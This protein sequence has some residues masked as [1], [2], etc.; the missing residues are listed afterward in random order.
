M[1]KEKAIIGDNNRLAAETQIREEQ[2]EV[3]YQTK[4]F[5]VELLVQK[6]LE[7]MDSDENEIF[8][9][10]YQREFVWSKPRQSKFIESVMLGLPIPYIFIASLKKSPDEDEGRAEIVD[11]S[12]RI[13]TLSDF[14]K[15]QLKLIELQKLDKLNGFKFSDLD[16]S[17]QRKFK[18]Q[19]I[20]VIELS[21]K[22]NEEVRRD[23]FER[24]NTGSDELRD[25]EKRKGIFTGLF[26]DFIKECA[27]SPEFR[28]VCP[29]SHAK[30]KREEAEEL[31]LRYFAYTD[32]YHEFKHSVREFLN[33][34]FKKQHSSFDKSNMQREFKNMVQFVK[35]YF[36]YGFCKNKASKSV[37][38]VR[39][40]AI[41]VGVTLAQ[42]ETKKLTGDKSKISQWL[43][44]PEFK[45]LVTSD[46][47]NSLPRLKARVEFVRNKLMGN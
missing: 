33:A 40:E 45:K 37:P 30:R 5:T 42:R 1:P 12:Q 28:A 13:R 39:F 9:P 46:A 31:V 25:M 10:D 18:R 21:E 6:Y 17:R 36:P 29:V 26:Y 43:E 22:A 3:D 35:R 44:S 27:N 38:R 34:Y 8:I 16:L 32:S 23:L 14:L 24:I 41:A 47:S 11:G 4:E 19:P 7:G 15:N 20:R 2:T